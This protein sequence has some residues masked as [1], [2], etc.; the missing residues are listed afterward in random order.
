MSDTDRAAPASAWAIGAGAAL[1]SHFFAPAL[2]DAVVG[3]VVGC[4]TYLA[5]E[6]FT[7]TKETIR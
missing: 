7:P 3:L 1:L 6:Q 4:L 2:S 5:L